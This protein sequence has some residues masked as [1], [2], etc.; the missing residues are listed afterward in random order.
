MNVLP[1]S[2]YRAVRLMRLNNLKMDA[3]IQLYFN[4][5]MILAILNPIF[6]SYEK[7][8]LKNFIQRRKYEYSNIKHNWIHWIITYM[9]IIHA[10]SKTI[11]NVY[12][13]LKAFVNHSLDM[14]C[15]AV[16]ERLGRRRQNQRW[17][18]GGSELYLAGKRDSGQKCILASR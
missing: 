16:S 11:R 10:Q 12:W 18:T 8:K 5:S 17:R 4:G 1:I 3:A 14:D 15:G 13:L 9:C 6:F 2:L 7:I